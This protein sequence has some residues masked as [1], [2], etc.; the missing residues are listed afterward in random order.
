MVNLSPKYHASR[1][2]LWY[3]LEYVY[4]D[5]SAEMANLFVILEGAYPQESVDMTWQHIHSSH[6]LHLVT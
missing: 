2:T 5:Y 4:E 3:F 6:S 1:A